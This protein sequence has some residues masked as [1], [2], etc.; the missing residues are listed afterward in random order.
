MNKL[1]LLLLLIVSG[2]S[3]QI[4][5]M[6]E[7]PTVQRFDLSDPEGDGV[8]N[9]RDDCPDSVLGAQID[10]GGCSTTT[11]ETVTHQLQILF[12]NNSYQVQPQYL[13]EIERL[14]EF[15]A[16]HKGVTATIEGHTSSLGSAELNKVLSKNRAQAIKQILVDQFAI[17]GQRINTEGYGE[18]QPLV[19]GDSEQAHAQNRRII[20]ALRVNKSDINMKW[21]IYTV[22]Q[23][24]SY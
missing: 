9:A 17:N 6:T 5:E 19:E 21:N 24:R 8:I 22:D 4:V 15:L 2:C 11:I 1:A 16:E 18:S 3:T 12:D 7:Q 14:A 13:P 20:V 23:N 10:N